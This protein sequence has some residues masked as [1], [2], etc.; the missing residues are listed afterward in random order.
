MNNSYL[1]IQYIKIA[2]MMSPT[3]SINLDGGGGIFLTTKNI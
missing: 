1:S 2:R 3:L